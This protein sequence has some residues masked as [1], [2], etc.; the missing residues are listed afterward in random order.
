MHQGSRDV[1]E[2]RSGHTRISV[3]RGVIDS[4]ACCWDADDKGGGGGAA[5]ASSPTAGG[6]HAA[7]T[8]SS[9]LHDLGSRPPWLGRGL[10]SRKLTAE[11][12][13]AVLERV[14][15]GTI[16]GRQFD[17]SDGDGTAGDGAAHPRFGLLRYHQTRAAEEA[18][19]A[20][21]AQNLVLP[22]SVIKKAAIRLSQPPPH[23]RPGAAAAAAPASAAAGLYGTLGSSEGSS[24]AAAAVLPAHLPGTRLDFVSPAH[25][26]SLTFRWNSHPG[27]LVPLA[28]AEPGALSQ[29]YVAARDPH[30]A[31]FR[32]HKVA[33]RKRDARRARHLR[34]QEAHTSRLLKALRGGGGGGGGGGRRAF[35]PRGGGGGGGG[36]GGSNHTKR[37]ATPAAAVPA[38]MHA[39]VERPHTRQ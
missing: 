15:R 36:G 9:A 21:R 25:S 10:A 2:V 33:R 34:E 35:S 14:Y 5:D 38:P 18:E 28:L 39:V 19:A 17:L 24:A 20:A 30:L 32:R 16:G 29:P 4:R 23:R 31:D 26:P 13:K 6:A 27:I 3:R 11:A 8:S 1:Y 22:A 37:A 12:Q 7:T